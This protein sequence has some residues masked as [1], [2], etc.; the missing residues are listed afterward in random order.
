[1]SI[2]ALCIVSM[3]DLVLAKQIQHRNRMGK[4]VVSDR[5]AGNERID[6]QWIMS[7]YASKEARDKSSGSRLLADIYR[8]KG[9][10]E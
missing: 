3:T 6:Y 9:F 8:M 5:W 2:I 10:V 1:M 4:V 7:G